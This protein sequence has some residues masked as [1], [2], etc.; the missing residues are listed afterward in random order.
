MFYLIVKAT[1]GKLKNDHKAKPKR[2]K[3][4]KASFDQVANFIGAM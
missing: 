3:A 1:G 4:P 2:S